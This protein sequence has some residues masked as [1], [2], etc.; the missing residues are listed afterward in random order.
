MRGN[1]CYNKIIVVPKM[2]YNKVMVVP[3][4]CHN[5]IRVVL[6][7]CVPGRDAAYPICISIST[8]IFFVILGSDGEAMFVD[9][10]SW[11]GEPGICC[12][13]AR[14]G[15]GRDERVVSKSSKHLLLGPLPLCI[16]PVK[17]VENARQQHAVGCRLVWWMITRCHAF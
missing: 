6:D 17:P 3:N 9:T 10:A 7:M 2:R 8:T 1:M 16:E 12:N 11:G 15:V 5:K 4:M 14:Q 13:Y